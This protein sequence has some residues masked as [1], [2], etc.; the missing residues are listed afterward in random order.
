LPTDDNKQEVVIN[1]KSSAHSV[2]ID[3]SALIGVTVT[4][5]MFIIVAI[6]IIVFLWVRIKMFYKEKMLL[7]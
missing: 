3:V 2:C 6:I 1:A 4:F 5:L 7:P